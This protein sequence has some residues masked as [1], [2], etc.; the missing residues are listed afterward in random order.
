MLFAICHEYTR[1]E[2][3]TG[4]S[5]VPDSDVRLIERGSLGVDE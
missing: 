3:P 5:G 2:D 4:A 1:G